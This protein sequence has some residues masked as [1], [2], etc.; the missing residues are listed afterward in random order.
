VALSFGQ[1][2]KTYPAIGWVRADQQATS[3]TLAE[4]NELRKRI[5]DMQL[6][7]DEARTSPPAGTETLSQGED[8]FKL[9]IEYEL[10]Y[11]T[12][13][14]SYRKS[15]SRSVEIESTWDAVFSGMGPVMLDESPEDGLQKQLNEW[16]QSNYTDKVIDDMLEAINFSG[17]SSKIKVYDYTAAV[18]SEDFH[19]ILVQL[20]ALGLITQSERRRSVTDKR[21]Y[22]TLTPYGR[23][24]LIQLRAIR[25]KGAPTDGSGSQNPE[26]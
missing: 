21:T 23:T 17:D 10:D 2:T 4:I 1:F 18:S 8:K 16:A 20:M 11:L 24:R 13:G 12:P 15:L 14:A 6:A 19:T 3:E 7:L 5:A 9:W 25:R 22:W 26:S